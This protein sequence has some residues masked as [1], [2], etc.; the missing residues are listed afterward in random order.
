[1]PKYNRFEMGRIIEAYVLNPK[2][3]QVLYL[4]YV[5]GLTHEQVA[6]KSNYST[7]QVKNICKDYKDFLIS[8]L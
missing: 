2:Y 3:R 8:L 7:Q 5:E 4:K 6:E 1:M